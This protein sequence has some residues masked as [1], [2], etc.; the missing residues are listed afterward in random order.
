MPKLKLTYREA[1]ESFMMHVK[2]SVWQELGENH[3]IDLPLGEF[4]GAM[5]LT[6]KNDLFKLQ[7]EK[8]FVKYI[9]KAV[10]KQGAEQ[11]EQIPSPDCINID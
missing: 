10:L 11:T 4:F 7:V 2:T 3:G 1:A 9:T 5:R 6:M 8:L